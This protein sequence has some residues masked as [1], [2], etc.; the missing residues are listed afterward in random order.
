M[1]WASLWLPCLALDAALRGRPAS[2]HPFVLVH[3]PAARRRLLAVDA[4]ARAA[5]LHP[6]QRLSEA[7]TL[8]GR[9][10]CANHDAAHT[11]AALALVA[12]WA[13]RHSSQVLLDPP[14][15]VALEVG[16]S[17][18]L[19]GS[20]H[21]LEQRLRCGLDELGFRHRVAL[22]PTP[23]AARV[24]ARHHD[25]A[26]VDRPDALLHAL[27]GI[28]VTQAGL[29][30]RDADMFAAMGI[31]TLGRLLSLPRAALR[32]RAGQ[33]FV[34]SLD[35]LL[36]H[37]PHGLAVHVPP[38]RF[39]TRLDFGG[40]VRHVHGLLFAL[41]RMLGD[42][43]AFLHARDGGVQRFTLRCVHADAAPTD[44]HVGLLAPER[45]AA[46][47]FEVTRIR[48]ERITLPAAVLELELHAADLPAFT[49]AG[50]DLFD[51]RGAADLPWPQLLERL[52]ARLGETAVY[53][54]RADADPRP[55]RACV[56]DDGAASMPVS[57][58][59]PRPTWLLPR[60]VPLRGPAPRVVAGPER[61]ET[62]WW[63]GDDVR[64]DYYIL[65]LS[66]G[67]R[68]WAFCA[69]G[70]RGPFMLHGWFA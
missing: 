24:L 52:R 18:T 25:G 70:E 27:A 46:T 50:H 19:F 67:Q 1:L 8:C 56:R 31:R 45:D 13:Y 29:P 28:P 54:L 48:L 66:G 12:A 34:E 37:R 38:E 14:R 57:E 40:E 32:R 33:A 39:H 64:R 23:H 26:T 6:G 58:R 47:L 11:R 2:P 42:L 20:W 44:I 30:A 15:G 21:A 55:E 3:G 61:L 35:A 9:L 17:L 10:A 43:A 60:P 53:R 5:G 51:R 7:E 59:P 22:A 68:A 49:P 41:K 16:R 69:P 62:G 4:A 36:G 65:E 63:D